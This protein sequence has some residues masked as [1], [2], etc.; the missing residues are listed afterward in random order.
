[1]AH[2]DGYRGG[3]A[4]TKDYDFSGAQDGVGGV[5]QGFWV[6]VLFGAFEGAEDVAADFFEDLV[7]GVGG[8]YGFGG[9]GG[10]AFAGEGD[11]ERLVAFEA[12]TAGESYDCGFAAFAFVREFA[13]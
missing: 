7:A 6:E 10:V 12:E 4:E 8:G 5:G 2:V 13:D 9:G 1:M 3:V 11:F